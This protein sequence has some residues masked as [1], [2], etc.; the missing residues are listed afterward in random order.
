MVIRRAKSA[1]AFTLVEVMVTVIVLVII[2]LGALGY[3]YHAATHSRMARALITATRTGQLLLEDWKS[4]G[5]SDFYDPTTL[6]LGFSGEDGGSFF[7]IVDG[8]PMHIGLSY[9][10]VDYDSL[11]EV[12]LREIAVRVGWRAD[13]GQE[14]PG[15]DDPSVVLATYVRRDASGS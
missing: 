9:N 10:D 11:A 1:A 3:E 13:H 8:L 7:I 12:T 4:N 6:G 5:G 14:A 15:S 2:A